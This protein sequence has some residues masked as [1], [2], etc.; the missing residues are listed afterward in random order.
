MIAKFD[1]FL[2]DEQV[3]IGN[4][5]APVCKFKIYF[6]WIFFFFFDICFVPM[7]I[8]IKANC[9]SS[10][11]KWSQRGMI[12][13]KQMYYKT[14]MKIYKKHCAVFIILCDNWR[15]SQS[16]YNQATNDQKRIKQTGP[17]ADPT[18]KIRGRGNY[19][20]VIHNSQKKD[21]SLHMTTT[22]CSD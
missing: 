7:C 19:L 18:S 6:P 8:L 12:M 11:W 3:R 14:K 22:A 10:L 21:K 5:R 13:A 17:N 1:F 16:Q 9:F 15:V 4:R 2:L 20:W